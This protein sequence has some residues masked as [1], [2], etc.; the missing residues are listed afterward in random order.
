M[1]P[2]IGRFSERV[3]MKLLIKNGRVIDPGSGIDDLLDVLVENGIIKGIA[4][5]IK[6]DE[7]ALIDASNKVVTPGLIDIHVHFREPGEEYKETIKTGTRAAAM[8]GFT[9]VACMPNTNPPIDDQ[10][11]VKSVISKVEREGIVNVFPVAAITKGRKGEKLSDIAKLCDAG[12]V[13]ISDD[14]NSVMNAAIMME[15]LKHA[16]T[17]NL[18]VLSH[19][20][21]SNLSGEGIINEGYVANLLKLKGIPSV[22]EEIIVDRDIRLARAV[23]YSIHITHVSTRGSVEIIRNA[24]IRGQQ[25]T[26]DTAPQY[27]TLTEDYVER[28][29]AYT[30]K[31]KPPLRT[32]DDVAAIRE[33]LRDGTIDVI[34]TDHAP[35]SFEEKDMEFEVAPVGIVGLETSLTLMLDQ[36]VHAGIL[37]LLEG[38][39]KMTINPARVLKIGRGSLTRGSIADITIIDLDREMVVDANSFESKGRNTPFEGWKLKGWPIMTIVGGKVVMKDRKICI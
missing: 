34:A 29:K 35:H 23:G 18:P 16:K 11:I 5:E 24:K 25:V 36:L 30:T 14:G 27:F 28:D 20:E 8:G 7:A 1:P 32:K 38:I 13:A 2:P 33:G 22:A 9:S 21:D 3:N 17:F 37:P 26:C 4:P 15:A 10:E 12:A 6:S 19:C 39:A 31:M